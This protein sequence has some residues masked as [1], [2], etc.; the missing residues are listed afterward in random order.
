M[1]NTLIIL[2]SL[3]INLLWGQSREEI[4]LLLN[5]ISKVSNSKDIRDLEQTKKI[6]DYGKD[7]IPVLELFF[8]DSTKTNVYSDYKKANLRKG[9]IA[10]LIVNNIDKISFMVFGVRPACGYPSSVLDKLNIESFL[11][12]SEESIQGFINNYILWKKMMT[13]K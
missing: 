3:T 1:K 4:N 6:C 8:K 7:A 9:E 13:A 2:F 11:P 5:D 12:S 10:I